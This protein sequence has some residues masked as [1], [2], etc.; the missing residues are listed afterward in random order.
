MTVR[1]LA[2]R[3]IRVVSFVYIV[4]LIIATHWPK[5]DISGGGPSFDKLL[6]F[7]AFG[8]LAILIWVSNWATRLW[9]L[10]ILACGFA[11]L[12]EVTQA[13]FS[14]GRYFSFADIA[15]GW[16]GAVS[17]TAMVLAFS[18]VGGVLARARRDRWF[19]A[20]N[21]ILAKPSGLLLLGISGAV[22][23]MVGGV[24][25]VMIDSIFPAPN[26]GRAL[27]LGAFIGC[28]ALGQWTLEIGVRRRMARDDSS[29][30]AVMLAPKIVRRALFRPLVIGG[31]V[32]LALGVLGLVWSYVNSGGGLGT[33]EREWQELG[34]E[35]QWVV[36]L[37]VLT[38]VGAG[39][40]GATRRRLAERVDHQDKEC[41][42]C[43]HELQGTVFDNGM[44]R[45]PECGCSFQRGAIPVS[46]T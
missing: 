10:L 26:A 29:G 16:L 2:L 1:G 43:M 25:F 35:S 6:H 24:S 19:A 3:N 28:V 44:A 17:A 40:I 36:D 9:T 41:L 8:V 14:V 34:L 22:G 45:C 4:V 15:A 11:L 5:L 23:V 30:G 7:L 12:D 31:V 20:A 32:L 21:A 37:T 18:P 13:L 38:L 27:F 39:I 46:S 33:W 42:S